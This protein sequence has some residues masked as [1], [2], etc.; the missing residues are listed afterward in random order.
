MNSATLHEHWWDEHT[1]T[2]LELKPI[3]TSEPVLRPAKFDGTPFIVTTDGS[4]DGI[5]GVLSQKHTTILPSGNEV[6]K[7]HPIAYTSKRTSRTE[8]KYKP[9]ILEFAALKSALDQFSNT[10]WGFPMEIETDFQALW[11]TVRSDKISSTHARW[12]DGIFVH[13]I[14]DI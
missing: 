11:D 7:L 8:E 5:A 1:D 3:L 4:K 2:F 13:H 12:C 6:F 14:A 9:F 10:I